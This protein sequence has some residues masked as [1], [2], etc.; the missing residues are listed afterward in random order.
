MHVCY[1]KITWCIKRHES[2]D[3][4]WHRRTQVLITFQHYHVTQCLVV[5]SSVGNKTKSIRPR[6]TKAARRRPKL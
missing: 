3:H 2:D 4:I 6:V 1:Q 5:H